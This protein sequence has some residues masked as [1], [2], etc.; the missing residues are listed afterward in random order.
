MARGQAELATGQAA[1]AIASFQ[2][3]RLY[4]EDYP[5]AWVGEAL[6]L[7]E[8]G[9]AAAADQA[10]RHARHAQER[11]E[12]T[13]R[14]HDALY[15]AACA[16]AVDGNYGSTLSRLDHLLASAPGSHIG[17]TVPIEPFFRP[18]HGLPGFATILERLA[19]QA[20]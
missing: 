5:R 20:K 15:I 11:F 4:V 18:L 13:G 2:A 6:A 12:R 9:D 1:Q 16:A 7:A 3:A 14:H 10:R 19:G 8:T 17:W